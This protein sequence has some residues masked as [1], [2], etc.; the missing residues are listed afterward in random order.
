MKRTVKTKIKYCKNDGYVFTKL[1]SSLN[2]DILKII[3][4]KFETPFKHYL[5][6]ISC[7]IYNDDWFEIPFKNLKVLFESN[8][9]E[10]V[11]N[12]LNN[13]NSS[14]CLDTL[15]SRDFDVSGYLC[16]LLSYGFEIVEFDFYVIYENFGYR[17]LFKILLHMDFTKGRYKGFPLEYEG[18]KDN[19]G[20]FY[21]GSFITMPLFIVN[22][23]ETIQNIEKYA[24]ELHPSQVKELTRYFSH[25]IL[26]SMSKENIKRINLPQVPLLKELARNT[27]RSYLVER[28]E[29]KTTRQFYTIL[30]FLPISSVYKKIISYETKL[31]NY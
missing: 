14:N 11:I 17:E 28:Y 4:E 18:F 22:I 26:N 1:L 30:N 24:R 8:L 15:I 25:P 5:I 13:F 6:E 23:T 10:Q 2:S 19:Y 27:F 21:Q 31:Y 16:Y 20:Y 3:I 9:Q 29:I 12:F 7:K